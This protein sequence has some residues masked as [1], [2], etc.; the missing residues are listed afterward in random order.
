MQ[1]D[2]TIIMPFLN[3]DKEPINTIKNIY[4]TSPKKNFEIIAI[5]D[6]SS[7]DYSSLS[8]FKEVKYIKNSTRLGVDG[9]RQLGS[10]LA[11]TPNLFI[12]DA[13]MRF[14]KNCIEQILDCVKREP[15]TFWCSTCLQLGYGNMAIERANIRYFGATLLLSNKNPSKDRPATEILEPKWLNKQ[16]SGEYEIPCILGAN[17]FFTKKRFD[18]IHGLKGLKMWGTSEPFL[19]LKNWLSGGKCKITTNFEI[20]HKFRNNAPYSTPVW[21]LIYN[22]VFLC[23][24][25]LPEEYQLK[26]INS[27]KKDSIFKM[28]IEEIEKE[29]LFVKTERE[30]YKSIFTKS[31]E[32]F[33]E[34]FSIQKL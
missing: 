26:L 24:T 34:Q 8:H 30:Y 3:E 1:K 16:G 27:F 20:G 7:I 23:K 18:Y 32:E 12:I 13:H 9:C 5:D 22:K 10:I 21:N 28:A 25:I 2:L 14:P 15:D 31:F 4:D 29:A 11:Q 19:S 17:Y 33:C 6:C